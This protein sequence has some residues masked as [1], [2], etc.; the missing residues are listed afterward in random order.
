MRPC[1]SSCNFLSSRTVIQFS[2]FCAF[3]SEYPATQ[4]QTHSPSFS[5]KNRTWL[6]LIFHIVYG[7]SNVISRCILF[8]DTKEP[9]LVRRCHIVNEEE[10]DPVTTA[11]GRFH[12]RCGCGAETFGIT[13]YDIGL[14]PS[15]IIV[16]RM[17]RA[18]RMKSSAS[19]FLLICPMW[20]TMCLAGPP[21]PG[22]IHSPRGR[23]LHEIKSNRLQRCSRIS[24]LG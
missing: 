19:P 7:F 23:S 13:L 6:T 12:A 8:W 11:L 4:S 3:S 16:N 18:S 9:T 1:K 10:L 14:S 20:T 24:S 15:I 2:T 17:N 5:P 21:Q 22:F